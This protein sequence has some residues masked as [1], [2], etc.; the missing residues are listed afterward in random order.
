MGRIA[1]PGL[2][3]KAVAPTMAAIGLERGGGPDGTLLALLALAV[4]NC[5]IVALIVVRC[6]RGPMAILVSS[7]HQPT[8]TRPVPSTK[9]PSLDSGL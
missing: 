2:I 7:A 1:F 6:W 3:A 4:L 8:V 5:A 9:G